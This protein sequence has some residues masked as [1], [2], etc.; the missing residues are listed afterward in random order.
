MPEEL[1]IQVAHN[2]IISAL[3]EIRKD[4]HFVIPNSND[5]TCKPD[6]EDIYINL[7]CVKNA[8]EALMKRQKESQGHKMAKGKCP[9][10]ASD[11]TYDPEDITL[12]DYGT[13]QKICSNCGHFFE[14]EPEESEDDS[15]QQ[16]H[17]LNKK[18]TNSRF[19]GGGQ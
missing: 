14:F 19:H 2:H 10:C 17:T 3:S 9:K 6:M 5:L 7:V 15:E 1:I 16:T 11:F 18:G 13:A 4:Y 8:L 12:S